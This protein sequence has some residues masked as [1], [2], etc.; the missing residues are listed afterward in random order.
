MNKRDISIEALIEKIKNKE[1]TLPEIQRRYVWTSTKVRDLLDSL[2]RCYPTGTILVWE[3]QG[4]NQPSRN[5]D[6]DM[7]PSQSAMSTNLMLLDG[8][9]RL[10]SL[11]ALMTGNPVKVK[12]RRKLKPIEIMFN[13]EHPDEFSRAEESEDNDEDEENEEFSD[14]E[15]ESTDEDKINL[16]KLTFVVYSRSLENKK[17]WV[18]VTDIFKKSGSQI[19]REIGLHSDDKNWDRYINRIEKVKNIKKYPYVM[20]VLNKERS[21]DEVTEI[22]VR[23]NSA[24]IK[25]RGSDLALAQI[26]SKWPG[27]LEI[28]ESFINEKKEENFDVDMTS[29][30]R[31]LVVYA[32]GQCKFQRVG[33]LSLKSIKEAWEKTKHGLSYA[34]NFLRNNTEIEDLGLLSSPFIII[35]VSYFSSLKEENLNA[36]EEKDLVKWIYL[37]NAFSNYSGSSETT[38][39]SEL[40]VLRERGNIKELINLIERKNGRTKINANDLKGKKRNSPFF[41]MTYMA[42]RKNNAKDWVSGMGISKGT[43]GKFHKIQSHHIFPKKVLQDAKYP[44]S[45]INEIA[46]LSFIGGRTNRRISA[47]KPENY[48]R[49]I[50]DK[51][52]KE[53]LQNQ[54]IPVEDENLWKVENFEKF[55]KKRREKLAEAVNKLI[56]A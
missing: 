34:L 42:A 36:Q 12:K 33:S 13:L 31:S 55:L 56:A 49:D 11:T 44:Q 9:Q 29:L 5:F 46:N 47:K 24:G 23:V 32:T 16:K 1:I 50:I 27:C 35:P 30:V 19:L 38:L 53:A 48:F 14:Q 18:K 40:K 8:Q 41:V 22:F 10:T 17:E 54:F 28:F 51:Q 2:Y 37:S 15:D 26:T 7:T 20:N 21:Y 43:K 45:E 25:L 6:V 3:N 39:N 4:R 52:G